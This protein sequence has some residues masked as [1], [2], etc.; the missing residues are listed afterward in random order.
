MGKVLGRDGFRFFGYFG[1]NIFPVVRSYI[2]NKEL[3]VISVWQ[4]FKRD[5]LD[6]GA[7]KFILLLPLFQF[8][9]AHARTI[10][11]CIFMYTS[12][13]Y[14]YKSAPANIA[15]WPTISSPFREANIS[16]ENF[17]RFFPSLDSNTVVE[18]ILGQ[19]LSN[20]NLRK[21]EFYIYIY[22]HIHSNKTSYQ[23]T[24]DIERIDRSRRLASDVAS[25]TVDGFLPGDV[26]LP[27]IESRYRGNLG[28]VD[29]LAS[30][31]R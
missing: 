24:F 19:F 27:R 21:H 26:L 9:F 14:S 28:P 22:T 20:S 5:P 1:S 11:N 7:L 2:L 29:R 13:I 18:N 23:R 4:V 8:I 25:T 12:R 15:L 17:W 30:F 10:H 31:H 16:S 6:N 3:I